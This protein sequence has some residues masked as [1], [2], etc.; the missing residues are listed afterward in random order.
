MHEICSIAVNQARVSISKR[1]NS[2]FEAHFDNVSNGYIFQEEDTMSVSGTNNNRT[3][4]TPVQHDMLP[5]IYR[6]V[7]I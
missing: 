4:L 7:V 1:T 3:P 6:M 5:I 2:L